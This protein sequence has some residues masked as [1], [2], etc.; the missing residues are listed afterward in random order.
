MDVKSMSASEI[1]NSLIMLSI[2]MSRANREDLSENVRLIQE[3]VGKIANSYKWQAYTSGV[4]TATGLLFGIA[5]PITANG[6]G[7]Y[8]LLG[9]ATH[10]CCGGTNASVSNVL[11]QIAGISKASEP[12]T[13]VFEY[14]R[15]NAQ[16][17]AEGL[18]SKRDLIKSDHEESRRRFSQFSQALDKTIDSESSTIRELLRSQ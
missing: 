14:N 10:F 5:A 6:I 12:L 15:Q 3:K 4:L 2:D 8:N 9:R 16:G 7:N 11:S 18:R 13:A 17:D 1:Y